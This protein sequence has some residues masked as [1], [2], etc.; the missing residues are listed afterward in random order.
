M[1]S[2]DTQHP[3]N[4]SANDA[5]FLESSEKRLQQVHN[6]YLDAFRAIVES[7]K[8]NRVILT[9][10]QLHNITEGICEELAH[11]AESPIENMRTLGITD[12]PTSYPA[13]F[14]KLIGD[15]S[16]EIYDSMRVKEI[17]YFGTFLESL[18]K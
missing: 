12:L 8:A 1:L 16:E 14:A 10:K 11:E 3:D 15:G 17:D 4:M 13:N 2:P 7:C 18:R 5:A 6:V 9:V